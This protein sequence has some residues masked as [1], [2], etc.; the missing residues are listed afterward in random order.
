MP[1]R[2][3]LIPAADPPET[4]KLGPKP[5]QKHWAFLVGIN[6]YVDKS[7]SSLSFC[8]N[9]VKALESNLSR[10]HY[11]VVCLHDGQTETNS[12]RFPTRRN[13]EN[14]LTRLCKAVGEDDLLWVHFACHGTRSQGHPVLITQDTL[15]DTLDS[16]ALSL[17]T[18]EALMRGS[19]A[20]RQIL[21]MDACETGVDLGR[22]VNR[23]EFIQNANELAEGYAFLSASTAKQAAQEWKG[24]KHGVF[25]YY[26]LTGL[27]GD[28]KRSDRSFI[29]VNDL[30][31]YVVDALRSWS[32]EQ[33]GHLQEPTYRAEGIGDMI[34]A[35]LETVEPEVPLKTVEFD[36]AQITIH[37]QGWR[38]KKTDMQRHPG[39]VESFEE[40]LL[41]LKMARIPRGRFLM[42]SPETELERLPS[43]GPQREVAIE[44]FFIGR[45][46]VTQ[47]QWRIFAGWNPVEL[48]LQPEPSF[49]RGANHPVEQVSWFEAAEFCARLSL[50]TGRQYR[51]PSEAEWEP[52]AP[53]AAAPSTKAAPYTPVW[54]TTEA[55]TT[56][57]KIKPTR[58]AMARAK[59]V[60]IARKPPR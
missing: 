8:I 23:P 14:A 58:A 38:G 13:I 28:A 46:L 43:E 12:T 40:P 22:D 1:D 48:D 19:R 50:K 29:T 34:L 27:K 39:Q 10:L 54:P 35:D 30:Q 55:P 16:T 2:K 47:A 42:G 20:K 32:I 25:T 56:A 52:A 49:F 3:A 37:D 44:S 33:E 21:T 51:L 4:V 59:P 57:K 41:S 31:T 26:L 11:T 53:T 15:N 17:E 36:Y 18:V 24:V 45:T 9:D 6:S 5:V 7:F 60:T